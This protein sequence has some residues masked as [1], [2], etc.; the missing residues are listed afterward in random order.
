MRITS[1]RFV[2]KSRSQITRVD[3]PDL[4]NEYKEKLKEELSQIEDVAVSFDCWTDSSGK[5]EYLAFICHFVRREESD[6]RI[7]EVIDVSSK[8]HTGKF[9]GEKMNE[10]IEFYSIKNKI[11]ACIRDG[12]ANARCASNQISE[13][14][15]DCFAHKLNLA[16]KCGTSVFPGIESVLQKLRKSCKA[17]RISSNLRRDWDEIFTNLNK[18]TLTL[19]KHIETRWTSLYEVL[20]RALKVREQLDLFL[21]DQDQLDGITDS[22]WKTCISVIELLEPLESA[23]SL[24]QS[25]DF[26][27]SSI[28]P[29]CKV[30]ISDLESKKK[31]ASARA[32]I[33]EKLN[34]ELKRYE[35]EDYLNLATLVDVRFKSGFVQSY[36]K[37]ELLKL[38]LSTV[39]DIQETTETS[40]SVFP[41]IHRGVSNFAITSIDD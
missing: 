41:E 16:A 14:N 1:P 20:K 4:F 39:D 7:L 26:S 21:T 28:I 5:H 9:L 17:I 37:E 18:P 35:E 29:L 27:C 40:E 15:F 36:W 25:R 33:V 12:A 34:I 11:R 32:K 30:I 10:A 2:V 31:N 8:S 24:V 19:K 38:M 3:I 22:E 13:V 23:F 6:Y